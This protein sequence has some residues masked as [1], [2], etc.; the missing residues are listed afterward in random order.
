MLQDPLRRY[1][2]HQSRRRIVDRSI[3]S[4]DG[5][6]EIQDRRER[7]ALRPY[8]DVGHARRLQ[9]DDPRRRFGPDSLLKTPPPSGAAARTN[10]IPP[11]AAA[12]VP[13]DN[14]L[15][16]P[17]RGFAP[18]STRRRSGE[19]GHLR[20]GSQTENKCVSYLTFPGQGLHPQ[21]LSGDHSALS[22]KCPS[23]PQCRAQRLI[24][25]TSVT[26]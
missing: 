2:R 9:T 21:D 12:Y 1:L 15:Q 3:Y 18:R 22:P 4:F 14:L 10:T 7:R 23:P 5:I 26:I 19:Q 6:Q 13:T 24:A 8:Y 16:E 20:P 11:P 25:P 17:H